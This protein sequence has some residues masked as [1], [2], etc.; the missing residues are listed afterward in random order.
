[1]VEI[2][3]T[4]SMY[5]YDFS[6]EVLIIIV[7]SDFSDQKLTETQFLSI[8]ALFW[9]LTNTKVWKKPLD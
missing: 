8:A 9:L 4:F 3:S 6:G 1:M 7:K 2:D 5:G